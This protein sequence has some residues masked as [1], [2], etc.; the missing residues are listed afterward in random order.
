MPPSVT[1]AL[2]SF[3]GYSI[4]NI[5]QAAQKIGLGM[6]RERPTAGWLL[7]AAAIASTTGAFFL[8]FAAISLGAVSV[9]GAM[10]GTGLASLAI[11]S[12]IVMGERLTPVQLVAL[13]AIIGG[14]VL[15]AVFGREGDGSANVALLHGV[16]VAGIVVFGGGWLLLRRGQRI[17]VLLGSFSGFLG[18]YSQ[19]YQELVTGGFPWDDG[20]GAVARAI[21]TDP[22][23]LIWVGLSVLSTLVI[24]FSYQHGEATQIIPVFTGTFILVPVLGGLVVFGEPVSAAQWI[25]VALLLGGSVV[26]GRRRARTT[27]EILDHTTTS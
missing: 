7:W 20:L 26:L 12:R 10:A 2:L 22:I 14:A 8:V 17:G 6:R 3:L 1:A 25:G 16:L 18:A 4:L 19:L 23:T 5:A 11:F 13:G 21:F 15:V 24:Q 27:D 9:A